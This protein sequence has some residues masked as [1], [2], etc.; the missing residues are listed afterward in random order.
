MLCDG[1]FHHGVADGEEADPAGRTRGVGTHGK[2]LASL[3]TVK[4]IGCKIEV[5]V[6]DE[7]SVCRSVWGI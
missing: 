7:S 3:T 2:D 1:S 6:A 4:R 5:T